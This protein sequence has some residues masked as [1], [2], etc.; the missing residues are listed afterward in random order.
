M[1][2]M[3]IYRSSWGDRQIDIKSIQNQYKPHKS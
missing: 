2:V 3:K 1:F